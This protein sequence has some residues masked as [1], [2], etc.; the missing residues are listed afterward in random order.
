[1]SPLRFGF[2][3]RPVTRAV[4]RVLLGLFALTWWLVPG[5][6][7]ID[8]TVTW[9]PDWPVLLEAGWGVLFTVGL[10]L[11][12]LLA[13]IRPRLAPAALTQLYAVALALL[14]GAIAGHEPQAWW[15]FVM[16][17]IELPLLHLLARGSSPGA[18]SLSALLLSLALVA[19]VPGLA[20][21]WQM[22][23]DNRLTLFSA[24]LTNDTD[25]YS[26][27]AALALTLVLLPAIAGVWPST[28][29]LLGSSTALMAAYLGL[30]SLSW[31]GT[32]GGFAQGWSIAVMVW[33]AAV[34][35][36]SW[37]DQPV[38]WRA[39]P[40]SPSERGPRPLLRRSAR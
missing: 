33:A 32:D 9:D 28:R 14:V 11:P 10:G 25:H 23:A 26:V 36:C 7:V 37:V 18:R 15:I 24:D 21:A 34:G 39:H 1:M 3:A 19:L 31:P 5:M 30:V 2:V 40:A 13:A 8:L 17:A 4:V 12:F 35:V 20:Y 6:G 29:R 22:A 16:L 27:Q 38:G